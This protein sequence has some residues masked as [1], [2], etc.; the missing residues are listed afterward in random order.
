MENKDIRWKQR[1]MNY[2][3]A[4]AQLRKFIDKGELN[5]LEEQGMIQCFEYT[6]ELGWNTLKDFFESK[7]EVGING[8]RDAFRLAFNRGVIQDG[9][10][11]MDMVD[12]RRLTVHTYDE[13]KADEMVAKIRDIYFDLF[14]R[15]ETRMTLES[16]RE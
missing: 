15:L 6:Y 5:E 4:L 8:S 14:V 3:K 12:D 7:G 9:E 16:N 2:S 11:W 10:L 1:L 13:E